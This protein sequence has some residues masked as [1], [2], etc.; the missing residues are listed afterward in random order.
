MAQFP[1]ELKV[2]TPVDELIEQVPLAV[3]VTGNP[4]VEVAE[5][6]IVAWEM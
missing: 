1:I 6:V 2:I 5:T 4:E 3:K